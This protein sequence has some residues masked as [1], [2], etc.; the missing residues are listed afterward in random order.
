MS[1]RQVAKRFGCSV[2]TV[3][4]LVQNQKKRGT[5]RSIKPPGRP[6]PIN[7]R[8]LHCIRR[9]LRAHRFLTPRHIVHLLHL[10]DITISL[11]TLRRIMKKLG[12]KRRV[13]RTKPFLTQSAKSKRRQYARERQG[14][15]IWDHRRTIYTDEAAL[16]MNGSVQ[17]W[18]TREAGEAYLAECMVSKLLSEK[19]TC[20]VWAAIWHGGRTEL[21]RFDTEASAGKRKG[22]T[23]VIY[24]DQITKGALKRAWTRVNS[25]YRAY[26]GAR[27]VE[28]GAKIH[29]SATNRLQG[30]RQ[31][32]RYISHPPSS[33]D[34]N[35]IENCWAW[36]KRK[37]GQL[38]HRPTTVEELFEKAQELWMGMPQ[39]VID[40]CIDSM[41]RRLAQVRRN[42]GFVTK[43]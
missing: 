24:R 35:P 30:L 23:A 20:M 38:P 32:F 7:R 39:S 27:I 18:V 11:S 33:P 34:L 2:S 17:R 1:Y 14:E 31:R 22:V 21:H 8:T 10:V 26:G 15:S 43:Y 28:D 13:A 16:R 42:A 36:L 40:N 9:T 29:T 19:K 37:L 3:S 6:S 25:N 5:Q 41:P 12:L 4:R